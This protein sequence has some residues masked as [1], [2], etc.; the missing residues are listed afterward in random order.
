[1][2]YIYKLNSKKVTRNKKRRST[3]QIHVLIKICNDRNGQVWI[4]EE[5]RRD[6]KIIQKL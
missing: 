3:C 1:M 6:N 2:P 4:I 5:T